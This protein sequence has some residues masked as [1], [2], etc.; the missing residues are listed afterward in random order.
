M[1]VKHNVLLNLITGCLY[2]L[3]TDKGNESESGSESY[4]ADL[5]LTGYMRLTPSRQQKLP[6][7]L[8]SEKFLK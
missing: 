3:T 1:T 5:N 7:T 6:T 2:W 8:Q 4:L